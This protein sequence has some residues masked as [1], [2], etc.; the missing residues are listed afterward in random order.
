MTHDEVVTILNGTIQVLLMKG[1]EDDELRI[2]AEALSS[3]LQS[4]SLDNQTVIH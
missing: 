2:L 4:I 1:K 3:I